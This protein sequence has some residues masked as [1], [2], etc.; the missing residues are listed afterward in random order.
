MMH[1]LHRSQS[2]GGY[3]TIFIWH[4]VY[5]TR[6]PWET[7]PPIFHNDDIQEACKSGMCSVGIWWAQR[8]AFLCRRVPDKYEKVCE[9]FGV[10][11]DVGYLS[12]TGDRRRDAHP[13][14]AEQCWLHISE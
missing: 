1:P 9:G 8:A 12:P 11:D 7:M 2:R 13:D 3:R 5:G 6:K 10:N 4:I 14:E